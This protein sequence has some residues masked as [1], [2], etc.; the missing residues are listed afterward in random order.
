MPAELAN[1]LRKLGCS[2]TIAENTRAKADTMLALTEEKL[3]DYG[4]T[5]VSRVQDPKM[6]LITVTLSNDNKLYVRW[7][8][9]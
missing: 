3:V 7:M 2:A 9:D 6:H 5:A 4:V 1:L 8:Q